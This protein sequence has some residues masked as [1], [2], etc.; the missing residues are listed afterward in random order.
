VQEKI[1][2]VHNTTPD[3]HSWVQLLEP[4]QRELIC[5][6]L[7]YFHQVLDMYIHY[8]RCY[9]DYAYFSLMRW[10]TTELAQPKPV[11]IVMNKINR[12]LKGMFVVFPHMAWRAGERLQ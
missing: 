2:V 12:N 4:R 7:S 5:G 6:D 10:P 11:D 1:R 9:L 8:D 3:Q